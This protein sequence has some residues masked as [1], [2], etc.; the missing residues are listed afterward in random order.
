[1]NLINNQI[2]KKYNILNNFHLQKL[3]NYNP[4]YIIDLNKIVDSYN[5]WISLLP[6]IKPYYAIKCNPDPVIIH[7]LNNLGCNF[8]CASKKEIKLLVEKELVSLKD[9]RIIFANP[10][11]I[12]HHLEYAKENNVNLL[13]F[14]CGEELYKIKKYHPDAKLILRLAVDESY[15]MCKFNKKFGCKLEDIEDLLKIGLILNLNIVGFSFHVGS[16]CS[17]SQ[18]YYDALKDCKY[19]YNIAK[20]LKLN[21]SIIDIGGGF[22]YNDNFIN[23]ANTIISSIH[24]F[25]SDINIKFIAEPGRYFAEKTHTL[26]LS[27]IGKK[28]NNDKISYYLNDSIYGSFNCIMYDYSNPIIK[29]FKTDNQLFNSV[30]FGCTCDSLDI[31]KE[32]I[33]FPELELDDVVYIENF[34]AYTTAAS[35]FNGIDKPINKYIFRD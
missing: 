19:A 35:N 28:K 34:G 31:I 21:I 14:D 15:S 12:S 5:L 10:C 3:N 27:V 22:T 11:K 33:M 9:D 26:F 13:T 7:L 24:I 25:F 17:S 16:N 1:M 18:V 8:D 23:Y 4:C 29:S 32:N 2:K 30:F 6:M 20:K